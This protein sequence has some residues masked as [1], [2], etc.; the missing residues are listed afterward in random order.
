MA[1]RPGREADDDLGRIAAKAL[2][3][4]AS[5]RPRG[6]AS[7]RTRIVT[8]L[9]NFVALESKVARKSSGERLVLRH[10]LSE[11]KHRPEL[12]KLATPD[13]A[14]RSRSGTSFWSGRHLGAQITSALV[15]KLHT[16]DCGEGKSATEV[17]AQAV[18]ATQLMETVVRSIF[19]GH[20]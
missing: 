14:A 5:P 2:C 3:R 10:R 4:W 8:T 18:T 9:S 17:E 13:S 16:G 1:R 11:A 20:R 19:R 12:K 6:W 7:P 15:L